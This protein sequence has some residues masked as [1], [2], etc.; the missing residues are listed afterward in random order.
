MPQAIF[1]DDDLVRLTVAIGV[2][3]HEH[4]IGRM[5]LVAFGWK[6]RVVFDGEDSAAMIDVESGGRDDLRM[7]GEE[8][9]FQSRIKRLGRLV[10]DDG[11]HKQ[12]QSTQQQ[13]AAFYWH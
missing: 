5:P 2:A 3:H 6:V 1:E 8:F 12:R 10:G 9:D 4:S 7:L 11:S 13:P